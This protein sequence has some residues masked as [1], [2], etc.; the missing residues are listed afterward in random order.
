MGSEFEELLMLS[1]ELEMGMSNLYRVFAETFEED[2]EF[3]RALSKEEINHASLLRTGE[4]Y[5][6][7]EYPSEML[8]PDTDVLKG[9][10]RKLEELCELTKQGHVDR[11]GAFE[12]GIEFEGGAGEMHYQFALTK[13]TSN[14]LLH[15][16]RE[17][18]AQDIHHIK[19]I[20]EYRDEVLQTS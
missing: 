16:F 8:C 5:I 6:H 7:D 1:V 14:D 11:K 10:R 20:R 2:E 18:N 3:W 15:L 19:R 12:I 4:K 13:M 9:L 17:L